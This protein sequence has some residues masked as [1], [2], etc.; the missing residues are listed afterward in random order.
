MVLF[1]RGAAIW[2]SSTRRGNTFVAHACVRK[3]DGEPVSL[4]DLEQFASR[5]CAFAFAVRRAT[6]F[7][8][9]KPQP[10]R[11]FHV[12]SGKHE[13]AAVSLRESDGPIK[14]GHL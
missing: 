12:S 5:S 14:A 9:G 8:Y 7:V 11:L 4:A 2:A 10:R 6:A 1:H 3:D 13:L